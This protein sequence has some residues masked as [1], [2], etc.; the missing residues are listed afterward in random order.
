MSDQPSQ[1]IETTA[2]TF[3]SDVIEKSRELPVVVDFWAEWCGPCRL[4]GPLLEKV[5]AERGG[6]VA[7]VKAQ[8]DRVPH[9][10]EAFGV[11][12]IPAVFAVVEGRVVDSFVGVLPESSL[13]AWV[14]R[15][16]PSPAQKALSEAKQL[17]ASDPA[18]AEAKY[19]L[20]VELAPEDPAAKIAL[21]RLLIKRDGAVEARA[22]LDGLE[23]RG[24]LEPDA[25]KLKA[26][27][28]LRQA[29]SQA[30]GL[31]TLRAELARAPGDMSLQLKLAEALAANERFEEALELGIA[32][33]ERDRKGA[34][35]EAHKLM[36]RI[37][38][39]LPP[40][41]ELANDYR[42]QLAAAL[43]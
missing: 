33:V 32:L 6:E 40:D 34:G 18:E 8:T 27:L 25:E 22:L 13:R 16:V 1:I 26:E 31:E 11:R 15:L 12:S 24:F 5:V 28:E 36:L 17:E 39:L 14:E 43:F 21:A 41:S 35:S 29:T 19:R 37:F 4:L 7:L 42:R 3:E 30:G 9:I 23:R 10:A 20:A 2:E 38:C